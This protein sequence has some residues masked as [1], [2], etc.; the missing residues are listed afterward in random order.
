MNKNVIFALFTI[1]LVAC[2]G[3][4]TPQEAR[5]TL[6][7]QEEFTSPFYA[8]I[9]LAPQ[10][11]TGENHTDP[12][13]FIR[14]KYGKLIDTG[15]IEA[16]LGSSN[17]WRTIL[18]LEMTDKGQALVNKERSLDDMYYVQACRIAVDSVLCLTPVGSDTILCRYQLSQKD[19]TPFGEYL[20]FT[21]AHTHFLD[22]KFVRST[23]SWNLVPMF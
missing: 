12:K 19:L 4:L 13:A 16:K 23:F 11:L 2:A 20:G 10:V 22:R 1:F 3:E 8:P 7:L 9:H 6:A 18:K 17:S 14:R 5:E 21:T 15:L